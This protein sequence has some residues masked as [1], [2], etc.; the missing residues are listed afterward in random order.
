MDQVN[1]MDYPEFISVFGSVLEHG[2]LVAASVWG[3]RPFP[4]RQSLHD[5]FTSFLKELSVNT[6]AGLIRCY[7]DLAGKMAQ[8]NRLS[9]DS[10]DE[11][12]R[13]GLLELTGAERAQLASLNSSYKDKFGF[14]FVICVTENKKEA[15]MKGIRTRLENS[16]SDEVE[17]A[18][19]EIS[20]IAYHRLEKIF[21]NLTPPQHK[22]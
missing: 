2:S 17:S 4:T 1:G 10:L 21:L 19:T 13:A 3:H 14:P 16:W 20:R 7:P 22:I 6:K 12:T 9:R 5:A 8:E 18:I 15:I 11:H